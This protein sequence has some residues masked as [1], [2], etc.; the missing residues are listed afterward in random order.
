MTEDQDWIDLENEEEFIDFKI[1]CENKLKQHLF[2]LR[3]K[4]IIYYIWDEEGKFIKF[5]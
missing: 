4:C 3:D 1:Y 2:L 5:Y